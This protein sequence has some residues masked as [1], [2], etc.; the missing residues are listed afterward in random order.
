[1][2]T[3]GTSEQQI[4]I[5]LLLKITVETNRSSR[6]LWESSPGFDMKHIHIFFIDFSIWNDV[7]SL[8]SVCE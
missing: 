4:F 1:M 6:D 2:T 5:A 3:K 8:S 7:L